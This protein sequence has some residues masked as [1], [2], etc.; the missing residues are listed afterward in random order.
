MLRDYMGQELVA[1]VQNFS[2]CGSRSSVEVHHQQFRPMGLDA[3]DNLITLLP[4]V[5]QRLIQLRFRSDN[6]AAAPVPRIRY[7]AGTAS[8]LRSCCCFAK[9][10]GAWNV[11]INR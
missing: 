9:E 2:I 3:E 11:V 5:T 10:Q 7:Q 1:E 6:A 4:N 8:R